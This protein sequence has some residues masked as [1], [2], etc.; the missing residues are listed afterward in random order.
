MLLISI[1]WEKETW[2]TF[3]WSIIGTTS[4][5][6]TKSIRRIKST[7]STVVA[8]S[9]AQ[10][11]QALPSIS[12]P[13]CS[14]LARKGSTRKVQ[15]T[16]A[17]RSSIYTFNSSP[18]WQ[19]TWTLSWPKNLIWIS[20]LQLQV[21]S[22]Q[23]IWCVK[24]PKKVPVFSLKLFSPSEC[25]TKPGELLRNALSPIYLR[26]LR[27]ECWF[28]Q[29]TQFL[30]SRTQNRSVRSSHRIYRCWWITFMLILAWRTEVKHGPLSAYQA[31]RNNSSYTFTSVISL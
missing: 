25:P 18:W 9:Q 16:F 30:Y 15:R 14:R 5:S 8:P 4:S 1:S 17:S 20:K 26:T 3:A 29:W 27:V 12:T 13:A 2:F 7:R 19:P 22:A 23:W 28:H 21:W 6:L 31:S 11:F 24:S 10:P